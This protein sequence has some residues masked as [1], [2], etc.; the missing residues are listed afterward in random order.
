MMIETDELTF[1]YGGRSPSVAALTFSVAEGEIFGFL[2]P[3]GAGKSTTQKILIRLLRGYRGDVR[4]MG[5]PVKSWGPDYFE[6][7][8]VCFELPGA[9]RRLTAIENLRFFASLFR[10][11][12]LAPEEVLG[13]GP[14]DVMGAI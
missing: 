7:V 9:Y 2:G 6:R 13:S 5:R 1:A 10:A 4:V 12:T 3:S 14:I 11:P 8:G